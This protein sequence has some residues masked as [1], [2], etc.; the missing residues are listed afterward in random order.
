MQQLY[1]IEVN[2]KEFMNQKSFLNKIKNPFSEKEPRV[3]GARM[4]PKVIK[5]AKKLLGI[6]T[7]T[8]LV[9]DSIMFYMTY[10]GVTTPDEA[11]R[12][13]DM[14]KQEVS[15]LTASLTSETQALTVEKQMLT[16][17]VNKYKAT[18]QKCKEEIQK[19]SKDNR[20]LK[21][22]NH[23]MNE[24]MRAHKALAIDD[25]FTLIGF[26]SPEEYDFWQSHDINEFMTKYGGEYQSFT[27][28]DIT[29]KVKEEGI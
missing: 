13:I 10:K 23:R 12:T 27:I 18:I 17:R 6:Q 2:F 4:D 15:T 16:E 24:Y 28:I 3:I 29:D 14:L 7:D 11:L 5:K 21:N 8:Q 1:I 25:S 19:Q 20:I 22:R 26:L 9:Q